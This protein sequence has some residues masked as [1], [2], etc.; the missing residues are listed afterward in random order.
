MSEAVA[1][2][3]RLGKEAHRGGLSKEQY[4]FTVTHHVL[5]YLEANGLDDE[6]IARVDRWLSETLSTIERHLWRSSCLQSTMSRSTGM[7][8]PARQYPP[9]PLPVFKGSHGAQC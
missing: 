7:R 6:Q 8:H 9:T 1:I 5:A 2:L 4:R 3:W